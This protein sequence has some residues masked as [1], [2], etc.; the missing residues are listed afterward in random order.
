MNKEK[1]DNVY[2][3]VYRIIKLKTFIDF[4]LIVHFFP[5]RIEAKLSDLQINII[6]S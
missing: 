4:I 1:C 3:V 6:L 2:K 5:V